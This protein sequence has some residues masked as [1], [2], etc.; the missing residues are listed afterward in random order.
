MNRTWQC[1][2]HWY[3][4]LRGHLA[5]ALS[6]PP[7][8][9]SAGFQRARAGVPRPRRLHSHEPIAARRASQHR[10]FFNGTPAGHRGLRCVRL[11]Y[12]LALAAALIASATCSLIRSSCRCY[13]RPPCSPSGRP[14]T[15]PSRAKSALARAIAKQ[16]VD[17]SGCSKARRRSGGRCQLPFGRVRGSSR[18]ARQAQAARSPQTLKAGRAS[19]RLV[20]CAD[21]ARV[22]AEQPAVKPIATALED[23]IDT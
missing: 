2:R 4:V 5:G 19:F 7:V 18:R 16:R 8:G 13:G 23:A 1:F 3:C 11:R 15:P 9:I 10:Q 12:Y 6:Q 17:S 22:G 14:T 20:A 21:V